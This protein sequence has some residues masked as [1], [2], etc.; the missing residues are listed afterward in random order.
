MPS[1]AGRLQRKGLFQIVRTCSR[2]IAHGKKL[3]HVK[4]VFF[5]KKQ[6]PGLTADFSCIAPPVFGCDN[7]LIH[8]TPRTTARSILI[9]SMTAQL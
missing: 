8:T 9:P 2:H 7:Q 4:P 3:R 1:V 5:Q 6:T